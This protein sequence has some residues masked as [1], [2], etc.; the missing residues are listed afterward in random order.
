[1]RKGWGEWGEEMY[2]GICGGVMV[3]I[4]KGDSVLVVEGGK[5]GGS[6]KGV[7]GGLVE[8]GERVEEWVEGEVMEERGMGMK[9]VKY[10]GREGWGYGRGMMVG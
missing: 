2:G 3:L 6:L 4:K 9:K 1:M 10:L 7:V 8:G 5:L